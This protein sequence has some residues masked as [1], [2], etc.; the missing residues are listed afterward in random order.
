MQ[1]FVKEYDWMWSPSG[2]NLNPSESR[3]FAYIYGLTESKN[4]KIN[5]YNGSV[6]QLAKD[7]GLSLGTTSSVLRTLQDNQLIVNQQGTLRSVQFPN[8]N[9]QF[10]NDSVQFPNE[11]VHF[12]N[13][14]VQLLNSPYTPIKEINKEITTTNN[15]CDTI[16]LQTSKKEDSDFSVFQSAFN[17]ATGNRAEWT[18]R[19]NACYKIWHEEIPNDKRAQIIRWLNQNDCNQTNPIF[20]LRGFQ[21]PEPTNYYGKQLPKGIDFYEAIYNGK[22]GLYTASDVQLYD[23]QDPQPFIV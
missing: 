17:N 6:R 8:N 11:N 16:A 18:N 13:K 9:V 4:T 1:I 21:M 12:P 20:F 10:L 15:T 22:K 23:M 2:L 3:V 19:E 7:L 14:S 5:G